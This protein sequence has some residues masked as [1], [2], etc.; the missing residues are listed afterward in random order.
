MRFITIISLMTGILVSFSTS[1]PAQENWRTGTYATQGDTT[2]GTYSN[3]GGYVET[4]SGSGWGETRTY[5]GSD[6]RACVSTG[7]S[8]SCNQD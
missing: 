8:V 4:R 7:G 3:G 2:T 5:S 1:A 6:G